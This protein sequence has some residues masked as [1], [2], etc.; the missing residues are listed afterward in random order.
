MPIINID[1]TQT[2]QVGVL[3]SY[4]SIQTSDPEATVLTTGYLN[5]EVANGA[6]F[7]LPCIAKVST[8]ETPTSAP[9]VGWYQVDHVGANW[10]LVPNGSPGDVVLPTIANHIATY[11]N[12]TG[13][14]SEDAAIAINGGSIQAGLSGTAGTLISYPATAANGKLIIA[15]VGNGAGNITTISSSASANSNC[16]ITTPATGTST[17]NFILS[18]SQSGTQ[19]I[20]SGSLNIPGGSMTVGVDGTFIN[21]LTTFGNFSAGDPSGQQGLVTLYP[22]LASKGSF[23]ISTQNNSANFNITIKN[24]SYGQSTILTIPDPAN[25]A[26]QFLIGATATPFTSGHLLSASGTAGLVADSGIAA[27]SVQ[28]SANIKAATTANIGGA[29]AGPITVAVTGMT[30]SSVVVATIATSSNPVSVV[31]AVAG[32]AGFNVTFSGDPGATCTLNYVA[33]IAAQ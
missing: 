16:V 22:S 31:K 8:Q 18:E 3:P 15:A 1:T 29:G 20:N 12:T 17:A 21:S 6:S 28:S 27:S 5:K 24:A 4:A 33:F 11:V 26:G 25:A 23:I 13:T 10:S 19:T 9:R 14:L 32:S 7:S 30:A 2:G